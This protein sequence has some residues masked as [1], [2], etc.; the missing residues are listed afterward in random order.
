MPRPSG[1]KLKHSSKSLTE[2]IVA[3]ADCA[4]VRANLL[5]SGGTRSR[6]YR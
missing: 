1:N 3:G 5:Y 4:L 2:V 6:E